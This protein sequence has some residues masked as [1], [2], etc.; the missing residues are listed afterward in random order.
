MSAL[1]KSVPT[2]QPTWMNAL[3]GYVFPA[4]SFKLIVRPVQYAKAYS[5]IVVSVVGRLSALTLP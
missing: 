1:S 3:A 4:K 2:T 5:P